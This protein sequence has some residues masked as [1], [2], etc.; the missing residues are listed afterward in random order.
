[1]EKKTELLAPAGD[2]NSFLAACNSGADAIYMGVDKFNARA[3]AKNFTK[4]E[5]IYAIKY[6]HKLGI[7]VFLTL[8]I[9][10]NDDEVKEA[11]NLILELYEAGLDAVILQDLGLAMKIKELFPDLDMHASTQLSAYSIEQVRLLEKLGFKRVVLAR[12]LT[13]KEIEY[14]CQNT[15]V[16]IEVFVHGALCVSMSGQCLMSSL[17]GHRSANRGECAQPCRMKYTLL[18]KTTNAKIADKQYLL[19]KKD[20]WG[21][22]SIEKLKN[23]GVYSFKIEGRNRTSQ[24]VAMAVEKYRKALDDKL[25]NENDKKDLQQMFIRQDKSE[26]FLNGVEYKNAITQIT[27]KNTGLLLGKVEDQKGLY[28]KIKLNQGINLHDGFEI[29]DTTEGKNELLYS[30]IITCIKNNNNK[31]INQSEKTKVAE[32]AWIGDVNK[33]IKFGSLIYKT[34]DSILNKKY[35]DI[36][37]KKPE[38]DV[39]VTINK[40]KELMATSI[41]YGE[42]VITKI[43]Y[44]PEIASNVAI[45]DEKVKL[46]FNKTVDEEINF[47]NVKVSIDENLYVP[48]S[49][50]NSLRKTHVLNVVKALNEHIEK[51]YLNRKINTSKIKVKINEIE[52]NNSQSDINNKN[53]NDDETL[54]IYK[55]IPSN[56]YNIE[57]YSRVYI[58]IQDFMRYKEEII[59][60]F[61]SSNCMRKL[62]ISIPNFVLKNVERYIKE[63]IEELAHLGIGGVLL[64]SF[65]FFEM[66]LELKK[67]YDIKIIADYS[68]NISNIY[69]ALLFKKLGFDIITP[70]VEIL[71]VE[72]IASIMSDG[73]NI[74]NIEL[75]NDYITVMTSRYCMIGAFEQNRKNYMDRCKKPC[76]KNDFVLIDSYGTEYKIVTDPYDCIMRIVK[77]TN[78]LLPKMKVSKSIRKCII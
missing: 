78:N 45:T 50:L 68:F 4:E 67:Q 51:E 2:M 37:K 9:L 28:V 34:S 53:V 19:S 69:T 70:S 76:L 8:N 44:I 56:D 23:A 43:D 65:E 7:K 6:A 39:N 1:M 33:K 66:C 5:Y 25:I 61:S 15:N 16:E 42:E 36:T 47:S 35:L 27:P 10:L 20:I 52:V 63:N 14:I 73:S 57:D 48:A 54:F 22:E 77:R 55:F 72:S 59:D 26:G 18:N 58:M 64:G 40:N 31:I 21:L 62:F 75:V 49:K 12:E 29:Y 11:L 13:I 32:Y 38:F 60:L 71:N 17:I 41:I 30:S 74:S 3:M 46:N 24:Y